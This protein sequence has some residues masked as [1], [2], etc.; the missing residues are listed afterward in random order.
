VVILVLRLAKL[1]SENTQRF[2][3]AKVSHPFPTSPYAC[4]YAAM[5]ISVYAE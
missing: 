4:C 5:Y 1:L 3:S 2:R